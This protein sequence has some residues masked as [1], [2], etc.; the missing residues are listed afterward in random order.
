MN[1]HMTK[2]QALA[3][4]DIEGLSLDDTFVEVETCIYYAMMDAYGFEEEEALDAAAE[5]AEVI[6]AD[7]N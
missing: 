6:I 3:A 2:T 4:L 5:M 7:R 1:K